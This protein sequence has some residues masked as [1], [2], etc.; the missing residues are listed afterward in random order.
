MVRHGATSSV[1]TIAKGRGTLLVVIS[2]FCSCFSQLYSEPTLSS[3]QPIE[4]D[5]KSRSMVARGEATL[6]HDDLLLVADEIRYSRLEEV[7]RA[8][9]N[10]ELTRGDFRMLASELS[11]APPTG[12]VNSRDFRAGIPPL[13]VEGDRASGTLDRLNLENVSVYFH[14]PEACAPNLMAGQATLLDQRILEF[15]NV[16][17][18]LGP[19]SL[20]GL[21]SLRRSLEATLFNFEG[22]L[23]HRKNLGFFFQSYGLLPFGSNIR[24]GANLDY[25]S[26]RGALFGPAL[27]YRQSSA[28]HRVAGGLNMGYIEDGGER[29]FQVHGASVPEDRYFMTW[30]HQQELGMGIRV[31]ATI[32][33]WSD[34]E[35]E[36]DFRPKEFEHDQR[37]DSFL[38]AS[39][40][41][42]NSM[43]SVFARFRPNRFQTVSQR[44][45]ELRWNYFASPL[46]RTGAFQALEASY[47]Q[48]ET[49]GPQAQAIPR[50][51]RVDFLYTLL[52]PF[53][54]RSGITLTALASSRL[55]HYTETLGSG[56]SFT[57][58]LG[59]VGLDLDV[60]AH[61]TWHWD[62]PVLGIEKFRHMVRPLIRYRYLPEAGAGRDQIPRI[63][64]RVFSNSLP[65]LDFA[66]IRHLDDLEEAHVLRFGIE[67]L[68]LGKSARGGSRDIADLNFYQDIVFSSH[69]HRPE[70]D[71]FYGKMTLHAQTWVEL[72]FQ[73]RVSA[74]TLVIDDFRS[75]LRVRSGDRWELTLASEFLRHEIE[76]YAAALDYKLSERLRFRLSIHSDAREHRLI[77]QIYA[78]RWRLSNT[79]EFEGELSRYR[80]TSRED[81]TRLRFRLNLLSF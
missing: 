41:S 73:T 46:A 80:G 17:M 3:R 24:V 54:I 13:F 22:G 29:G 58:W 55:T 10:I 67:N 6:R 45:P 16:T 81:D 63:D 60:L 37:P 79:W 34:S 65:S 27:A 14:E 75:R 42:K 11:Y 51:H 4:F 70:W 39:F 36:R 25:Y 43:A 23:G 44:I 57:R 32:S 66:D 12:K 31:G 61:A 48:L 1:R 74:P 26:E 47:A 33:A 40:A 7:A 64:R 28:D 68:F 20:F 77:E 38:E 59:Q 9:G 71:G 5:A 78:L 50:S 56:D 72:D 18:R 53:P 2:L 49:T 15:Q 52:R 76:Q 35:I 62:S 21:P 30:R 19:R 8:K 69:S